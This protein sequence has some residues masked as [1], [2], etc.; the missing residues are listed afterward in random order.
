MKLIAGSI[1]A[2]CGLLVVALGHLLI[3]ALP[4]PGNQ[5]ITEYYLGLNSPIQVMAILFIVVGMVLLLWGIWD[6]RTKR[7]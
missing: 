1:L 7:E 3:R 6:T 5:F 2:S 4:P